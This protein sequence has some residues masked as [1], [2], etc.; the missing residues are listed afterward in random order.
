MKPE[1][2]GPKVENVFVAVVQETGE[3]DALVYNV[4]LINRNENVLEQLLVSSSGYITI[5]KTNEKI[6]TTT[7]RK[8]L[9]D[10]EPHSTMK[11]EPIMED[12]LGLNN[13]YWVSF[14]IGDQ[15]YDKRFIFLAESIK[16]E[17]FVNI[18]LL[19]KNGVIVG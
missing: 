4:Y 6:E 3:D 14:W 16:E 10:I 5:E 2:L 13:E 11:I 7:L 19:N 9:G 15:L 18:P 12:V 17:N 8:S 1:L